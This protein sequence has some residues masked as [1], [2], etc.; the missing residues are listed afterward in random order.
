MTNTFLEIVAFSIEFNNDFAGVGDKVG[1]VMPHRA[2]SSRSESSKAMRFQL[3]PKQALGTSHYASELLGTGSLCVADLSVWHTP[4]P[5]P[6]P[7]GER[8]PDH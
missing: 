8:E 1:D 7:Q 2:L 6:P 5:D 4:L 3:A